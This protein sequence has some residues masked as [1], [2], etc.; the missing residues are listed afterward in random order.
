[1]SI[2]RVSTPWLPIRYSAKSIRIMSWRMR[3]KIDAIRA[4][5]EKTIIPLV[6]IKNTVTKERDVKHFKHHH[7]SGQFASIVLIYGSRGRLV[8]E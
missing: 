7:P 4:K 8:L 5:F 6:G 2:H 1:M 3:K